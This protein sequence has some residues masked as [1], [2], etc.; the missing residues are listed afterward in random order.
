MPISA[1]LLLLDGVSILLVTILGIS[2]HQMDA[3]LLER[4]PFTFVPFYLC[5]VL[6]A[7]LLQLYQTQASGQWRQLWRVPVAAAITALPAAALRSLWLGTPLAP[8]FVLVMSVALA[9]V[10]LGTRSIYI[11]TFGSGYRRHG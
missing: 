4:L 5:W 11:F 3:L 1:I 9:L 8:I 2:F 6:V 7:A 10:L